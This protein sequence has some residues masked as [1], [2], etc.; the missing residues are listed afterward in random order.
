MDDQ[1]HETPDPLGYWSISGSD[2]LRLLRLAHE[3]NDPDMVYAEAY[4]N[5]IVTNPGEETDE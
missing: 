5:S 1:E 2:L 4:A 3:G